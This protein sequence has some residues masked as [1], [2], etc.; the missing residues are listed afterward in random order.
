LRHFDLT[1]YVS[2]AHY[3]PLRINP[4]NQGD[5]PHAFPIKRDY[6]SCGLSR[7]IF[8][9]RFI[10]RTA[11]PE[12]PNMVTELLKSQPEIA[13]FASLALGYL[14]GSFRIGPIQLGCV[15]GTLIVSLLLGQTGARLASDLKN[16]AFANFIFA[17]G[18][19]GGPQFFANIGRQ[20]TAHVFL[21]SP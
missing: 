21:K 16:I 8:L 1:K 2:A 5:I 14:I 15:C 6:L 9:K 13:L 10:Q 4:V 18:F 17:F 3:T 7:A 20:S 11:F 19:T 12:N